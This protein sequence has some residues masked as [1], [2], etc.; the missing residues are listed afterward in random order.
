MN[1]CYT[2]ILEPLPEGGFS[3]LV[4]VIPEIR[5]FGKT[6]EEAI[7]KLAE[8]LPFST[9]TCHADPDA[10]SSIC[11]SPCCRRVLVALR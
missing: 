9:P 1:E 6:L 3:G 2:T 5:T 11:R 7:W 4:A 8:L 10:R